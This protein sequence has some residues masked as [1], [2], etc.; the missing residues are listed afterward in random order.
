MAHYKKDPREKGICVVARKNEP[1][2]DMI[3]R[4]KKKYSKSGLTKEVRSKMFYVKPGDKKRMKRAA[5][6]RMRQRDQEKKVKRFKKL[7]SLKNKRKGE[8]NEN[9]KGSKR[10]SSSRTSTRR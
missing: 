3:K 6:E 2:A 5:A 8:K 4:F 9:S 10:Q 1:L 7:T